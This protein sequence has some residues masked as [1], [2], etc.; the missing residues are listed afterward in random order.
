MLRISALDALT[1]M[2]E[3]YSELR[4]VSKRCKVAPREAL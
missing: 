3:L 4:Y 2:L 1:I